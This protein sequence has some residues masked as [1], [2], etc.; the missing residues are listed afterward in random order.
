MQKIIDKLFGMPYNFFMQE[1]KGKKIS[2]SLEDYLEAI[3]EIYSVKQ[4]VKAIDISKKLNV[5][6]SSVTEALKTLAQKELVNYSRYGV[7]SLTQDGEN[8]AKKV[9]E[10]HKVLYNFFKNT[11]NLEESEAQENACRVEHVLSENAFSAMIEFM[12]T[13]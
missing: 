3:Y 13:Q 7:L 6:R 11:L 12:K 1:I 8:E 9:I 2:S 10:K 5:G 4:G